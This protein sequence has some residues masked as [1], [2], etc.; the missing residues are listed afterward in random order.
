MP[1]RKS[2][3]RR[4]AHNPR[5]KTRC[6]CCRTVRSV[7]VLS[8]VLSCRTGYKPRY[9]HAFEPVKSPTLLLYKRRA[10]A[11]TLT[12]AMPAVLKM[13]RTMQNPSLA[14]VRPP[15]ML[16]PVGRALHSSTTSAQH[17]AIVDNHGCAI[18]TS[19]LKEIEHHACRTLAALLNTAKNGT[20]VSLHRQQAA[21]RFTQW[22]C[23]ARALSLISIY[24]YYT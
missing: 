7:T 23:S 24:G 12:Q 3:V 15:N 22:L 14:P 5:A 2:A 6:C 9:K 1:Q 20:H 17:V 19:P 18:E 21:A 11:Q 4:R 10:D 13:Q 8:A 16:A